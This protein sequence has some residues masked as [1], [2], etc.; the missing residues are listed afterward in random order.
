MT[1]LNLAVSTRCFKQ[2]F[3]SLDGYPMPTPCPHG[4]SFLPPKSHLL[5]GFLTNGLCQPTIKNSQNLRIAKNG[6]CVAL[7]LAKVLPDSLAPCWEVVFN[8]A[9]SLSLHSSI[10]SSSILIQ[11]SQNALLAVLFLSYSRRRYTYRS[12]APLIALSFPS[13]SSNTLSPRLYPS[14]KSRPRGRRGWADRAAQGRSRP[15]TRT[16]KGRDGV[17]KV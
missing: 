5:H 13:H 11:L 2:Y 8:P 17:G 9:S 10:L 6:S 16:G 1:P 15:V 4:T 3:R 12:Y 14:V 7:V